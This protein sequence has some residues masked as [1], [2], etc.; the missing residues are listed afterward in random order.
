[1]KKPA[2]VFG[3]MVLGSALVLGLVTEAAVAR[4]QNDDE[5]TPAQLPPT[6]TPLPTPAPTPVPT[7]IPTPTPTPSPTPTPAPMPT[8]LDAG[9]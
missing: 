9:R 6:P 5:P 2:P 3:L 4:A 7:P 1:M 8:Y